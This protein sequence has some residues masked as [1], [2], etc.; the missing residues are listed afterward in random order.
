MIFLSVCLSV[1]MSSSV[2]QGHFDNLYKGQGHL[3]PHKQALIQVL[4]EQFCML[5][6][7]IVE[8]TMEVC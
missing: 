4:C 8:D 5:E 1:Y 7:F 6:N 3:Y 2:R